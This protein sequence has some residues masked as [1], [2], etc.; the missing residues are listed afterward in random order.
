ML[1]SLT[2]RARGFFKPRLSIFGERY[3]PLQ[4]Y[5]NHKADVFIVWFPKTGGTW[6]RLLVHTALSRHTAIIPKEPLEFHEFTEA[7]PNIPLV[8]AIHDDEP[9]WKLPRQLS[10][11][12]DRYR[13]KKVVLLVR[14]PR[15]AIVSLHFQMTKRWKVTDKELPEFIWQERGSL[16]SMIRYYNIWA[17]NRDVPQAL[18]LVRYED[19]HADPKRKL[20][21][22]L[23][24]MGVKDIGDGVIE[25]SVGANDIEKL[26]KREAS[27]QYTT[28]RLRPGDASDPSSFKARRGK[29]GGY[30][31]YLAATDIE[32]ISKIVE[33]ELDPWFGYSG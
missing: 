18:L 31:D 5:K 16:F 3:S 30:V 25:D 24:F 7:H 20:R 23:D 10:L 29:V 9:H 14:D 27:M 17:Q 22:I 8:R 33:D 1:D 12:K 28:K 13:Q 26:R 19:I 15:D 21:E 11:T 2:V 4:W 32:K 6:V